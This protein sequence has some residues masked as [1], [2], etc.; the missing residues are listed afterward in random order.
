MA[1]PLPLRFRREA[2][3]VLVDGDPGYEP[4]RDFLVRDLGGDAAAIA[5]ARVPAAGDGPFTPWQGLYR[6]HRL[7]CDGARVRVRARARGTE[8]E[9]PPAVFGACLK[10]Y[11]D[12]VGL[13][14][15][16]RAMER[17]IRA[18]PEPEKGAEPHPKPGAAVTMLGLGAATAPVWGWGLLQTSGATLAEVAGLAPHDGACAPPGGAGAGQGAYWA[19]IELRDHPT[20]RVWTGTKTFL[21][22]RIDGVQVM[23]DVTTLLMSDA[24]FL[25]GIPGAWS[26]SIG[27]VPG[28]G[29]LDPNGVGRLPVDPPQ[30]AGV[31]QH[32]RTFFPVLL[33]APATDPAE[34]CA[35]AAGFLEYRPYVLA[36][37]L[38][39]DVQYHRHH[40]E[41]VR[42]AAPGWEHT[43]NACHLVRGV[44]TVRL[45]H[46][47]LGGRSC[48]LPVEEFHRALDAYER[49]LG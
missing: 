23:T 1:M 40:L 42:G 2:G 48:E 27:G 49:L 26:G 41:V 45:E 22:G 24:E 20:G 35:L 13:A 30:V 33:D 3:R 8:C 29:Y 7:D 46:L 21:P 16:R 5:R 17:G 38:L 47:W 36:A 39:H 34:V 28:H 32:F 18:D 10:E 6:H 37:F 4:L 11:A 14:L 43:G 19:D 25:P 15:Q 12:Q 9:V 31:S 44:E